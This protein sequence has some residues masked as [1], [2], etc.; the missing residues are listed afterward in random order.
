MKIKRLLS[1]VTILY[2]SLYFLCTNVNAYNGQVIVY[3]TYTGECYHRLGCTY[4]DSQVE[5]SLEEAVEEGY[6]RCSRC[7]PPILGEDN[8]HDTARY[9]S[10]DEKQEMQRLEEKEEEKKRKQ[11]EKENEQEKELARQKYVSVAYAVSLIVGVLIVILILHGRT[12]IK[13]ELELHE[14][15]CRG[16]LPGGIPGMPFGTIIGDDG[17]PAQI[18]KSGWGPMYTFYIA[19]SGSVFHKSKNCSRGACYPVHAINIG[20]RRPCKKC[21]PVLPNLN[22]FNSYKDAKRVEKNRESETQEEKAAM[23]L[24]KNADY[25][26]RV[27]IGVTKEGVPIYKMVYA[28]NPEELREKVF[29]AKFPQM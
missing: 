10:Y 15:R 7:S 22:W 12:K 1:M 13:K 11:E 23:Y 16:E 3:V 4:L 8:T 25:S 17:L 18:G 5:I 14:A 2:I 28:N 9:Y 21:R 26:L 29:N 27:K 20:E 19:R 24:L 6:Y